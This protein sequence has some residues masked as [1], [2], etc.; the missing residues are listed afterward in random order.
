[1]LATL[2]VLIKWPLNLAYAS[3]IMNLQ[4]FREWAICIIVTEIVFTLQILFK[5]LITNQQAYHVY[6][7][8]ET[9]ST[10]DT[11]IQRVISSMYDT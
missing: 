7:K 6:L 1:M 8:W 2:I 11:K 3:I 10:L 5:Y 4:L 9:I